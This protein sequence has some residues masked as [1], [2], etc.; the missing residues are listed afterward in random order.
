MERGWDVRASPATCEPAHFHM[1]VEELEG[2]GRWLIMVTDFLS[3]EQSERSKQVVTDLIRRL[4]REFGKG[5]V[6]LRS[7]RELP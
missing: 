3:T 6:T 4:E 5:A 2:L 1:Q 7:I